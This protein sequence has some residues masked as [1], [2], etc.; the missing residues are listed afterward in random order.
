[1]DTTHHVVVVIADM[2]HAVVAIDTTQHVIVATADMHHA[3]VV[4]DITNHVAV[5]DIHH[6]AVGIVDMHR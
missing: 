5:V 6:V 1:M 2:Y 3:V 4:V